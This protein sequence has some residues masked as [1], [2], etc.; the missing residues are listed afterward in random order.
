MWC[1][2]RLLKVPWTARSNQSILKEIH[3]EYSL[4]GLLL[5]WSSNTLATW[6]KEPT[7]WKRCWCWE[8]LEAKREENDRG[9]GRWMVSLTEWTLV[10]ANSRRQWRTGKAGVLQSLGTWLTDWTATA[11]LIQREID[12]TQNLKIEILWTADSGKWLLIHWYVDIP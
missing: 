8:R 4:E 7:H 10:W 5:K 11:W 12:T 3:P 1:W 9:W 6:C 2:R